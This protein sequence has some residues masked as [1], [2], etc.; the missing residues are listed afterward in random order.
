METETDCCVLPCSCTLNGHEASV[1]L[2]PG[3]SECLF[4]ER[5]A[6]KWGINVTNTT[7][8]VELGDRS[9]VRAIGLAT[10]WVTLKQT[11]KN[12]YHISIFQNFSI[13]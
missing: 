12:I 3:A 1:I 8:G 7:T 6:Q 13:R 11:M 10:G 5:L 2:D 4:F 9:V